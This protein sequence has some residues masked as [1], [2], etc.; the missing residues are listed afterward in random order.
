MAPK[1][2]SATVFYENLLG[3][4]IEVT[5]NSRTLL[6]ESSD[7]QAGAPLGELEIQ[8]L[9]FS[10]RLGDAWKTTDG[11][12]LKLKD[13]GVWNHEAGPDFLNAVIEIDEQV[14]QAIDIEIDL[15]ATDWEAHGHRDNPDFNRVGIHFFQHAASS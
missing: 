10:G 7:L 2:P 15:K 11:R 3:R 8:A 9:F 6:Q 4:Y 5:G 1:L 14:Q 13:P 12:T